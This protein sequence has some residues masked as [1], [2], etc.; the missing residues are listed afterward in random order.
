MEKRKSADGQRRTSKGSIPKKLRDETAVLSDDRFPIFD[1]K[2]A[3]AALRLR[4]HG[5]TP[6]ERKRII[7]AA[8][9]YAPVQADQA[10]EEDKRRR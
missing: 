6:S 3:I 2:S 1:K 4:G 9:E 10:R 8:S 7:E 5:T